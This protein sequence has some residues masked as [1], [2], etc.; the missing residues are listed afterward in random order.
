MELA[1]NKASG[2]FF[3][4]LDDDGGFEFLAITPEGK[5]RRLE[6]HLFEIQGMVDPAK[7]LTKH[8]LTKSQ[9][10]IYSKYLSEAL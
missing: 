8:R 9:V 7:A 2:K 6:R 3:V 1:K 10:D 5:I 4:I